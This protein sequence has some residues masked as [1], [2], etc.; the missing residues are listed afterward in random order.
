MIVFRGQAWQQVPEAF[1]LAAAMV[2]S[3]EKDRVRFFDFN[4]MEGGFYRRDLTH[5]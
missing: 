1:D 2:V 4:R 5:H 3:F